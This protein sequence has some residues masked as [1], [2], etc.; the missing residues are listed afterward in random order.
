MA[1]RSPQ[2]ERLVA[3]VEFLADR[4]GPFRLADFA[5]LVDADKATC[6]PMLAELTRVGWLVKDPGKRTYRLGPKLVGIGAAAVHS[7]EIAEAARPELV[8][9]SEELDCATGMLVPSADDLIIAEWINHGERAAP[10]DFGP[11]DRVTFQPP[12]GAILVAWSNFHQ[13]N[14][15]LNRD[16]V[17]AADPRKYRAKLDAL[18]ESRFAVEQYPVPAAEMRR[19]PS[20][21]DTGSYGERRV[22]WLSD[23]MQRTP[24]DDMLVTTIDEVRYYEILGVT[25]AVFDA[26][27][28][29]VG[30]VG[31]ADPAKPVIGADLQAIGARV[32]LA[33]EKVT[34]HIGGKLAWKVS[35]PRRAG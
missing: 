29:P 4:S 11:G 6:L 26:A 5:R 18:R 12:I 16:P 20:R 8:A 23:E 31:I 22:A 35:R 21:A 24:L 30:T 3:I 1:R 25:A 27:G 15:W 17:V 32:A 14:V 10:M 9:L 13:Q 2:T 34:E 7:L 19:D 28:C 33:A